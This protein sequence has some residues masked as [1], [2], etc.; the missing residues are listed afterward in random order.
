[1]RLDNGKERRWKTSRRRN[2]R[3]TRTLKSA[4]RWKSPIHV[5]WRAF[6][7]SRP[8]TVA[9]IANENRKNRWHCMRCAWMRRPLSYANLFPIFWP[10][11]PNFFRWLGK[12]W[13]MPVSVIR[14]ALLD[15]RW[16]AYYCLRVSVFLWRVLA[17]DTFNDLP[18]S[19]EKFP[20]T[21]VDVLSKHGR[22]KQSIEAHAFAKW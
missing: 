13:R 12:W 19:S 16:G 11:A 9:T 3:K 5:E 4:Y 2:D 8:S 20:Q 7:N 6:E 10:F 14:P 22:R 18:F 1:M 21:T 17:I 15:C